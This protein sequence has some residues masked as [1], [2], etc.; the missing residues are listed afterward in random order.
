MTIM[1]QKLFLY[2]PDTASSSVVTI[3]RN[4]GF[5]P[6]Q[7]TDDPDDFFEGV[8][9]VNQGGV[10]VLFSHGDANG[11]LMVRGN[12]GDDMTD[13]QIHTLIGRL[14]ERA[15]TFYCLS[16]YTGAVGTFS[17]ALGATDINWV[18]PV[19]MANVQS[20]AETIRVFSTDARDRHAGWS[21]AQALF[22]RREAMGLQIN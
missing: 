12:A 7:L 15:I 3:F 20:S 6:A 11:P 17:N 5:E 21:G 14:Q 16:C 9:S 4:R 22:P 13:E 8:N 19:G 10:L 18:A 2:C 1:P